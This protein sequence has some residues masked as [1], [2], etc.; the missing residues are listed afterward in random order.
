LR[1]SEETENIKQENP[2][3]AKV[4]NGSTWTGFSFFVSPDVQIARIGRMKA[5]I[6]FGA[7]VRT[8]S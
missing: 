6:F 1:R 5:S 4:V 7:C 8:K 2:N 3:L